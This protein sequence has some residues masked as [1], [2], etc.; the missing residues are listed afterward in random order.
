MSWIRDLYETYELNFDMDRLDFTTD[1]IPL[2]VSHTTANAQ[3][4][5]TLDEAG[6]FVYAEAIG[7][8]EKA[9]TVIPVSEDSAART[10]GVCAHPLMD[11]LEY[12]AADFERY[13]GKSNDE[14]HRLYVE[15]LSN[16][17]DSGYSC[18]EIQAVRSYVAKGCVLHDLISC[19]VLKVAE[20]GGK[21]ANDKIAGIDQKD[22]FVRF[23]VS[24]GNPDALY[25]NKRI[26]ELYIRYCQSLDGERDICYVTG[27]YTVC[28]QKHGSKIR[29]GGDKAKL[30][31]ANDGS[32]FTYRGRF[33]EPFQAASVG[34]D[35][36]QKAHS[37]LR[38]L[39]DKNGFS[40]GETTIVAWEISGKE[41]PDI[42]GDAFIDPLDDDVDAGCNE[43][44]INTQYAERLRKSIGGYRRV[45]GDNS[46]IVVMGLESATPG[47]LSIRFYHKMR[48]SDFLD[49]IE[50]WHEICCWRRI[51][52]GKYVATPPL[53]QIA[54]TAFGE[55]NKNLLGNTVERLLPCVIAGGA[56]PHDIVRAVINT[57]SN[58][59]SFENNQKSGKNWEWERAV[60]VACAL[61]RKMHYDRS[62]NRK[63]EN[64]KEWSMALDRE[65]RDRSY[66][67]GRLLG[68]AKKIEEMALFFAGEP[69]R[70]TNAEK[71]YQ[72]F[73]QRPL[74]TWRV[75]DRNLQPYLNRLK[76]RGALK[77]E[78]ALR[79]IYDLITAEQ[80]QDNRPLSEL[81]LLGYNCQYNSYGE[82]KEE[83][84]DV[85]Q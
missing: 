82:T 52:E 48:G 40:A 1:A 65:E 62:G 10:S 4:E 55:K 15:T 24:G 39:I 73:S 47:R 76:N 32:G 46:N 35:V 13:T 83:Q 75:I 42:M 49:R 74:Q 22:S 11:K 50:K 9:R 71:Y 19:G 77:Y 66:L 43:I 68:A 58:P 29:H 16:W 14:K 21:L 38:W 8:K 53:R 36:S 37:A 41:I 72:Q 81:Y 27:D 63:E 25:R 56:I 70:V 64:R 79:E 61:I 5:I 28:A 84:Q 7:D 78:R 2:P 6:G 30:I 51:R 3:I 85:E 44:T 60:N 67:F 59:N 57:A 34:Y 18:E 26:M 31:S 80:F 33:T 54:K 17:C 23:S 12:I 69:P 20:E 45:L